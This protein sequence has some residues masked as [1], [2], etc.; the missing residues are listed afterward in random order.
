MFMKEEEEPRTKKARLDADN[1]TRRQLHVLATGAGY[2]GA[3][4]VVACLLHRA[5]LSSSRASARRCPETSLVFH[6]R[7]RLLRQ[8]H[9]VRIA[10]IHT[11][12]HTSSV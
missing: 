7:R 2:Y 9:T 6:P 4:V 12:T 1:F 3:V 5:R 10:H 8:F 11:H